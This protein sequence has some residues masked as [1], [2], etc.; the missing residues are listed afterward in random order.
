MER[1]LWLAVIEENKKD[2]RDFILMYHPV[3]SSLDLRERMKITARNAEAAA[4]SV[5]EMIRGESGPTRNPVAEFDAALKASA[6]WDLNSLLE[7]TWHGVPES[8][9]CW[10]IRGFKVT[11]DLL[12]DPPDPTD[13]EM[14]A[15][16]SESQIQSGLDASAVQNV[17]DESV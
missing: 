11:V 6:V 1:T 7:Q 15:Y 12:D 8:T 10:L 2:L 4:E 3:Y 9:D 5:R 13:E 16:E 17:L 14:A